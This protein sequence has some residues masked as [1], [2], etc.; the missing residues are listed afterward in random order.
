MNDEMRSKS[1]PSTDPNYPPNDDIITKQVLQ[2][3]D[4]TMMN[5]QQFRLRETTITSSSDNT[6]QIQDRLCH[7]VHLF[8]HSKT[9]H[10]QENN[11][12]YHQRH[13]EEEDFYT[14]I[15][16]DLCSPLVQTEYL[17]EDI[18]FDWMETQVVSPL[19]QFVIIEYVDMAD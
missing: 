14:M 18:E 19:E 7:D 16:K 9:Q 1:I 15:E 11:E 3:L 13:A 4:N 8:D 2:R 5:T 17:E 10:L 12:Y 6:H